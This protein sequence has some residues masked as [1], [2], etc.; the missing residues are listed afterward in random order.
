KQTVIYAVILLMSTSLFAQKAE[1]KFSSTTVSLGEEFVLTLEIECGPNDKIDYQPMD[2]FIKAFRAK[3]EDKFP[4]TLNLEILSPFSSKKEKIQGKTYWQGKYSLIAFDT[5]YLILPPTSIK[6]NG[7]PLEIPPA[8]LRVSLMSKNKNIDMYDIEESFAKLPEAPTDWIGLLKKYGFWLL[9]IICVIL[10]VYFAFFK[11]K[12]K[13]TNISKENEISSQEKTR[14]AL[15]SLMAKQMWRQNL[16]KEHFTEL[17]LII[18][19][20]LNEEFNNRFESK[21][22]FEIQLILR[23]EHFSSKQ[24]NDLGLI[25]NVS[26]MVKF[27]QSSVEEEGIQSI[28]RKAVEFVN[29]TVQK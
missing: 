18:R 25:L 20:F 2:K 1:S 4:D 22:S 5:G 19:N 15:N 16:E 27:A 3:P 17:S 12:K 29:E 8:L 10:V 26:D 21:T 24:L 13:P 14:I 23:K 11:N 7:N 9:A 6:F 28:Y